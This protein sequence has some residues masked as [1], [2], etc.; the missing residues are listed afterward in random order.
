MQPGQLVKN[1]LGEMSAWLKGQDSN[2]LI[3]TGEEG[4]RADGDTGSVDG[5][6]SNG[7]INGGYKGGLFLNGTMP[8]GRSNP[9]E[10]LD[11]ALM[12]K[13]TPAYQ[14]EAKL[15][16]QLE[17]WYAVCLF[18]SR[19]GRCTLPAIFYCLV[20]LGCMRHMTFFVLLLCSK[21]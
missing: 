8:L 13:Q 3:S 11:C 21:P 16:G 17:R 9:R 14:T 10:G 20:F 1:W 7:W 2:H 12:W 6:S 5:E 19:S 15:P 18:N 4:Y